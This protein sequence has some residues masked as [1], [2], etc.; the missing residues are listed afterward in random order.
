MAGLCSPWRLCSLPRPVVPC[1][2]WW[3][4]ASV[5]LWSHLSSLCFHGH[6]A[7]SSVFVGCPPGFLLYRCMRAKSL[8]S[9]PTLFNP[10]DCSPPSSSVHGVLLEGILEWGAIFSSKAS[11]PPRNGIQDS[12]ISC[13]GRHILYH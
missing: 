11:S 13:I 6:V 12:Y 7:F 2:V 5:G 10:M 4:W 9:C 8:Q 3:L 1:L